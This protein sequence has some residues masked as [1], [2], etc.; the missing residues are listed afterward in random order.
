MT[1][2]PHGP[3][4][5]AIAQLVDAL[6]DIDNPVLACWDA[7]RSAGHLASAEDRSVVTF[8]AAFATERLAQS[9]WIAAA[10]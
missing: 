7:A 3:V 1:C 6:E 2:D 4:G 8:N 5:T 10:L 9:Q